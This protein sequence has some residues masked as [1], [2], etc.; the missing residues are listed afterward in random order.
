LLSWEKSLNKRRASVCRRE[1]GRKK[2]EMLESRP[3]CFFG[4]KEAEKSEMFETGIYIEG[5]VR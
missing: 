2:G 1:R 3:V 5:K 4:G